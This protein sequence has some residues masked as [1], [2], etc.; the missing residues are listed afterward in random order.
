MFEIE[1]IIYT[2]MNLALNKL[3]R[4]ICHKTKPNHGYCSTDIFTSCV[5]LLTH[6][7]NRVI[8]LLLPGGRRRNISFL[9]VPHL[10]R[11]FKTFHGGGGR[12]I[13]NHCSYSHMTGWPVPWTKSFRGQLVVSKD[14]LSAFSSY[15]FSS[16]SLSFPRN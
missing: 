16:L 13:F 8:F 11:R 14:S 15:L 12:V 4:L 9:L 10:N 6:F 5:R 3:Q 1:L 2:K 7:P